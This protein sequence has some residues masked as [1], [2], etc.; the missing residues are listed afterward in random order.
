MPL[1]N[2]LTALLF[3]ASATH[4]AL[5]QDGVLLVHGFLGSSSD[6]QELEARFQQE[7]FQTHNVDYNTVTN[8]IREMGDDVIGR[9]LAQFKNAENVNI[10]TH[11]MGGIVFRAY[12]ETHDTSQIRRVVMLAPPNGGSEVAAE[13]SQYSAYR[14]FFGPAGTELASINLQPRKIGNYDL[15]IIAGTSSVNPIFSP[16]LPGPDDGYVALS[17][18]PLDGMNDFITIPSS[19]GLITSNESAIEQSVHFI[20]NGQFD[21]EMEIKGFPITTDS[22]SFLSE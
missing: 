9:G 19:H 14:N 4:A 7:G 8:S 18:T 15:G 21:H 13:L 22:F 12:S 17:S 3:A 2:L 16:L 11:S 5:A 10:V 1:K 6:L 20:I